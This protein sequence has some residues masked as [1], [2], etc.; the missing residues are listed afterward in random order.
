MFLVEDFLLSSRMGSLDA[1]VI[2]LADVRSLVG[3]EEAVGDV[4]ELGGVGGVAFP[5][6]QHQLP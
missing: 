2:S 1:F 4:R 3:V 5:A 6:T